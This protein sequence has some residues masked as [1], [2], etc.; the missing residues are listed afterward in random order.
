MSEPTHL[1]IGCGYLGRVVARLWLDQG[2]NVA[3]LTRGRSAELEALGLTAIAGDVT[4]RGSLR[5]PQVQTVLYAVGLDR[6]AGKPMRDVYVQGLANVLD[7]LPKP[8]RL[9]YVSSTSV[10][11]QTDGSRVDESSPT[12][13]VEESGRIVLDAERTLQMRLPEA[14]I[15]RFAGIYGPN[16]VLRKAAILKGDPL[17]GDAEKWL[18]LIRVEDGASA[19]L[20][21]EARGTP[22]ETYNVSDGT[23]MTRREFYTT[24]AGYLGAPAAKFEPGPPPATPEANRRLSNRK[25]LD[26]LGVSLK[27]PD[28][29]VGLRDICG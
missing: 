6:S 5:L 7:A 21:A 22:G 17:V 16:R 29:R 9:I 25:M 3:A 24:M 2:R 4:D 14:T 20:A 1:I 19:V 27:Y 10:Y 28:F 18:N 8:Q 23:P 11:G 13:P 12:E 26:D 15:L